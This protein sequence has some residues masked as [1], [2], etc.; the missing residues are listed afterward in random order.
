MKREEIRIAEAVRQVQEQ[1]E[2]ARRLNGPPLELP[3]GTPITASNKRNETTLN[4]YME[5]ISD[6]KVTNQVLAY[7]MWLED[8]YG[9]TEWR[10]K[11]Y[12]RTR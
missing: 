1:I 4:Y 10:K 11:S 3:D 9:M 6:P 7:E 5:R 2:A 12:K 8:T